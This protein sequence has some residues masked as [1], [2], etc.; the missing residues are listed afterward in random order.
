MKKHLLYAAIF[1]GALSSCSNDSETMS[2]QSN[3]PE[4]GRDVIKLA[5]SNGTPLATTRGTGMVGDTTTNAA[6]AGQQLNIMMMKS[7]T[8][9]YAQDPTL[10]TEDKNVMGNIQL[11]A[12]DDAK[13]GYITGIQANV[14]GTGYPSYFYYPAD[15]TYDFYGYHAD[16]AANGELTLNGN[17]LLLPILIDGTQDL[18]TAK[19]DF[20]TD[21]LKQAG[22]YE[23]GNSD[24]NYGAYAA[25]REVQPTL[26]FKHLLTRLNFKS[27]H[28]NTKE[29]ES[30]VYVTEIRIESQY[31]GTMAVANTEGEVGELVWDSEI[32]DLFLM[33]KEDPAASL[34]NYVALDTIKLDGTAKQIGDG[35]ILPN[36]QS[37]KGY[38][39]IIQQPEGR[40]QFI[41]KEI[42][43]TLTPNNQP[44]FSPST[45]Y[46]VEIK[47]YGVQEIEVTAV[48]NQWNNEELPSI[49]PEDEI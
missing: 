30:P 12:P 33:Q 3:Q 34:C 32:T 19:A 20:E 38:I 16:N 28:I 27:L 11:T 39:T 2:L 26:D 40:N 10:E 45:S 43:F 29:N 35:I 42:P 48:L 25:R 13:E 21:S 8:L 47:V 1:M 23:W 41:K 5:I 31:K 15:G 44:A 49:T 37:Y 22:K 14:N 24:Y 18:M 9:E 6:W 7:N 4:A 17:K 46:D 36:A